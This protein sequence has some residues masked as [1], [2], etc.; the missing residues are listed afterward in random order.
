MSSTTYNTAEAASQ[1]GVSRPTLLR[2]FR[3]DRIS[4]VA[5]DWRGWR[6][7]TEEDLRRIQREL[8][9]QQPD[10]PEVIVNDKMLAYLSKVPAFSRLSSAVLKALAEC[11]RFRGFLKGSQFFAP[12]E[13]SSG[14][15][16]LVKG[17]VKVLRLSPEG[18]EQLLTVVVPF[19]TLGEAAIF[20]KP[21]TH[22]SYAVCQ[23]SS[24]ILTLPLAKIRSLTVQHPELAL[25][26][27][28]EFATRIG[29]LEQRLEETALY[30]LER[31]LAAHLLKMA[32]PSHELRLSESNSALASRFGVAR[33]SV[34][35]TLAKFEEQGLISRQGRSLV[36]LSPQELASI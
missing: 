25:V 34:S 5:R 8:G 3:E 12:G 26:F 28:S 32:N 22:S 4:N 1:L 10:A 33:E 7:F 20:R 6:Q 23:E 2:W 31:R 15:H 27:L 17:R 21:E 24:T 16:L 29:D 11:S 36:L 18:R 35:R 13:R 19:Q 14:L 30:P 9:Q